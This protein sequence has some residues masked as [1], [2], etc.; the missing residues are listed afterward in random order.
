MKKI[1][2][3]S[4]LVILTISSLQAQSTDSI[5]YKRVDSSS[6]Y[7]QVDYPLTY[8]P[9]GS[10]PAM[11]FFF[12]GG[13]NGG[14]IEQFDP[15]AKYFA[16]MGVVCF[17]A[18]YRVKSR[19]GTS[20]FESLKDAKSAIRYIRAHAQ[21]LGVDPDKIIASGGSAGGHLAVATAVIEGFNEE[22]EDLSVSCIPNALVLFN[23]VFDNGPG[24]YGYERI[25]EQY[26]DFSPLHNL[27]EGMPPAI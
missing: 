16:S 4:L 2:T 21:E 14:T 20:P 6:L 25:G 7:M 26:K 3:S 10:Y 27:K 8:H 11:V 5:L 9:S 15:H 18:D 22:G 24:G 19:Q 13:W 23:P 17:R 12:G 1:L